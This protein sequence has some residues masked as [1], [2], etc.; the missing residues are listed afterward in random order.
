MKKLL[1]NPFV[2]LLAGFGI[3]KGIK[4][5]KD[6]K[7]ADAQP[8]TMVPPKLGVPVIQ[9]GTPPSANQNIEGTSYSCAPGTNQIV[10]DH[11]GTPRWVNCRP[12]KNTAFGL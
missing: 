4:Y 9:Y 6:K 7:E 5:F 10:Y 8:Q 1:S 12:V 3:Y 11:Y 2:L